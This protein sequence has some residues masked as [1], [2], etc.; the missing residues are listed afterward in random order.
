[1]SRH[2]WQNQT[3]GTPSKAGEVL[4]PAS[5]METHSPIEPDQDYS[6]ST[7]ASV[8]EWDHTPR[9][10][11]GGCTAGSLMPE[12][13]PARRL[14]NIP[15]MRGPRSFDLIALAPSRSI[16]KASFEVTI[17]HFVEPFILVKPIV[18]TIPTVTH[19]HLG[20]S[21]NTK[22]DDTASRQYE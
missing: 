8:Q 9:T 18:I 1:M 4:S 10:A 6:W 21:T 20:G 11:L 17:H 12:L 15:E 2:I 22:R 19:L 3:N 13:H 5:L 16:R 14:P 7:Q